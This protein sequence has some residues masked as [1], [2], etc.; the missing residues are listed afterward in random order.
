MPGRCAG[1]PRLWRSVDSCGPSVPK[2][3]RQ[4]NSVVMGAP[5]GEVVRMG[6]VVQRLCHAWRVACRAG[7]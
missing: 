1:L 7:V 4:K 6:T 2:G 5:E 3:R